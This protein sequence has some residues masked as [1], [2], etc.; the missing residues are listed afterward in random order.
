MRLFVTSASPYAR[1]TWAAVVELGLEDRVE[2]VQAPIRLPQQPK[3]DIEA[4]NP[5]GKVPVLVTDS[6]EAIA[7][8]PVIVAYLDAL[9]GGGLIPAGE[10]RWHALTLEALADGCMDAGVVVRL[11]QVRPAERRDP[12]EIAAH[13]GKI[14]RTLDR[15]EAAPDR[16]EQ[17]FHVGQLALAC[18]LEWLVFRDIL[19]DPLE[20][21]LALASFLE[22]IGD[23]PALAAT[24]PRTS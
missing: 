10:A 4:L 18:A 12:A 8:S 15:I 24:R 23:R 17:P 21:R 9:A 7:D 5:L 6:G 13:Q 16:L 14:A 11:E 1:K 2:I 19:P 20:G 22:R 3:P